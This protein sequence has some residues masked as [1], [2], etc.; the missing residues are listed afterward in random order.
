METVSTWGTALSTA[1]AQFAGRAGQ[2]LPSILGA[3]L[4]LLI[5]WVVA[6]ILRTL[7]VRAA[8][9]VDRMLSRVSAPAG[10]SRPNLPQSSAR[11]LGSI[12]FWIVLLFFITAATQVLGLNAF[13]AWLAG[14][15][16]YVPTL[17]AGVLII[18][19]GFLLARLARELVVATSA[20]AGAKQRELLGRTVQA[21]ILATALLVGAD[22]VGI[23]VT[24][25]VIIVA[26]AGGTIVASVALA[27]SL[28][29]RN[30]VA[31]LIGGHHFRQSFSVGQRVKLAGFEGR[32]LELTPMTV[33]LETAEGRVTLPAKIYGEEAI[34]LKI[35]EDNHG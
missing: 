29:A 28:G 6:R 26:A 12:V 10:A 2:Y 16:N 27:F 33:I 35:G 7:A 23:K 13:T 5:G 30:Y 8:V 18:V 19:A 31:N 20:I 24:F 4:L 15:V 21:V 22:Q 3:F 11:I 34:V 1:F 32:I 17:F 14:V 9:V 25:L